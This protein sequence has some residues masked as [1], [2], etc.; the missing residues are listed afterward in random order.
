M[1]IGVAVPINVL[2]AS[3]ATTRLLGSF[4]DVREHGY[5]VISRGSGTRDDAAHEFRQT[6]ESRS[7]GGNISCLICAPNGLA[8]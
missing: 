4:E 8:G 1:G 5:L 6:A 2:T 7:I 3:C